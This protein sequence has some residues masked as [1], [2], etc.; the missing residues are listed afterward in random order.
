MYRRLAVLAAVGAVGVVG[1]ASPALAHGLGGRLDL[2]VPLGFFV[3]AAAVVLVITFVALAILWPH[4]RFQEFEPEPEGRP[5][6]WLWSALGA[7][8]VFFL[9]LTLV[10]GAIGLDNSTRN[11]AAVILFVGFWLLIPFTAALLV[12]LYPAISPWRRLPSWV[13]LH[14]EERPEMV[15]RLGY[16]PAT[17]V[18]LLFTWFELVAPDNGPRSI[19]IAA[20]VFTLYMLGM[21]MW[22]GTRTA[23]ETSDGFAVYARFLGAMAPFSFR[24][25]VWRERGWLRGLVALP[26]R[27]GMAA[28][29]V[30]MI[31]TVTYDGTA[32]TEWWGRVI[33]DPM[34]QTVRDWGLSPRLAAVVTGTIGWAVVIGLVGA[35]Y[36]A[37]SAAA[38]RLGG[39]STGARHVARRF[40]HTL[41]PI[42]FAYAFAH[43]FTLIVFEGQLFLSTFSDPFGFGWD[44]F[45]TADRRVDFT[46]IQ[47]SR[48][49][50][51]YL[52]VGVIVLGHIGGVIL[53]HDR[54]LV[55]FPKARAVASQ[56]AML[57][58]MVILTGL[59]LVILAA[60]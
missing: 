9:L 22:V 55:D 10:A 21:S 17:V 40:A 24:D 60:G 19:G 2:P 20:L 14:P 3:V 59:G 39:V 5:L 25:G 16:W 26:E 35:T 50:V 57:V 38:A 1:G 46:L 28:F 15:E 58:L 52:Q 41:V 11:P 53:S 13:G 47:E 44:L 8:G 54:A 51:W 27:T 4:A 12:D 43:Y 31:G 33:T 36:F 32:A 48:A 45:G 37:A 42:G 49:W 6:P 30:A 29:V 56:Y 34:L 7:V 18:F 23:M